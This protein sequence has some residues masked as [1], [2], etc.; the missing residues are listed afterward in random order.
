[1][2]SR[3]DIFS[4]KEIAAH[5]HTFKLVEDH[6]TD[7]VVLSS[8]EAPLQSIPLLL[9]VQASRG[10]Q[11]LDCFVAAKARSSPV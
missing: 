9:L 5:I 3:F 4:Q 7:L 8:R 1:M 2:Y 6:T 10:L 11:P